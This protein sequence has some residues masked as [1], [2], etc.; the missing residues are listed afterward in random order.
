MGALLKVPP[1]N[2]VED[3]YFSKLFYGLI[4]EIVGIGVGIFKVISLNFGKYLRFYRFR[5]E[6]MAYAEEF[7]KRLNPEA[8]EVWR[9]FMEDRAGAVLSRKEAFIVSEISSAERNES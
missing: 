3:K 2:N 1:F 6:Y 7:K 9:R 8:R 5:V 4:I